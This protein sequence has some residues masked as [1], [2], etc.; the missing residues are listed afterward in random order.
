MSLQ[1]KPHRLRDAGN[2]ADRDGV[3]VLGLADRIDY[4]PVNR[5]GGQT[6]RVAAARALAGSGDVVLAG[7]ART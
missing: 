2:A 7:M 1:V 4:L 3:G 5:S 6:Q